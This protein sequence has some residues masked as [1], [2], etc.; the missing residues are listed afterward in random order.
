MNRRNFLK[1]SG[2]SACLASG[3]HLLEANPANG[4]VCGGAG[5]VA[6]GSEATL[7]LSQA[8]IIQPPTLS[9]REQKAVSVLAEEVEKRTGIQWRTL[10]SW[11]GPASASII[12][13]QAA[14]LQGLRP[15]SFA[16]L[17]ASPPA[18]AA[19]GFVL[20]TWTG[21]GGPVVGVLGADERGVLF[22]VGGLLRALSMA[23][24]GSRSR[25]G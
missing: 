3:L 25:A 20:R 7:D 4:V 12:I 9:R 16:N 17:F 15:D 21:A 11:T 5:A 10:S 23:K 24:G 18:V 1:S 8:V 19:E 14:A 13:G 22:G 2:A 6:V